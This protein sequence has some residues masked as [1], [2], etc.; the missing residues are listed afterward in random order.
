MNGQI[1]QLMTDK[2]WMK[3]MDESINQ[4]VSEWV[5]EWMNDLMKVSSFDY[6]INLSIEWMNEWMNER[7]QTNILLLFIIIIIKLP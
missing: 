6:L 3:K 2:Q 4:G 7:T 1:N 5:S